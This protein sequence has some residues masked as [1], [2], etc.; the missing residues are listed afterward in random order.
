[1]NLQKGKV[2]KGYPKTLKSSLVF[3]VSQL[4]LTSLSFL[5][6]MAIHVML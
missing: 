2:E 5:Y 4:I 1:M 3:T 6:K